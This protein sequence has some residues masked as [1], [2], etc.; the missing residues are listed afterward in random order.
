MVFFRIDLSNEDGLGHYNRVKS[1]IKH[2]DLKKYKIVIDK[3][4]NISFFQNE[5]NNIE[6]LYSD[7]NSF[8]SEKRDAILF[9]KLIGNNYRNP[10]VVKDSYR[11][12]LTWEKHIYKFCNKIITIE[13]FIEKKH[14]VDYYINYSPSFLSKNN[15]SIEMLKKRNKKNCTF[16]LGPEYALF[17]SNLIKTK[18][19]VSDL[20]FYNGGSGDLLIYENIIKKISK[21]K[22]KLFKIILI[23]GPLAKNY[24]IIYQKF[25]KYQNVKVLYQPKNILN[26]LVGTKVFI[27]SAGLSIFESSFLK[28]PTLLFKM[29]SN[30]NLS[31]FDYEKLGHYFSLEKQ[32]LKYSNQIVNLIILMLK[33]RIEI[34]KMMSKSSLNIKKIKKNYQ[35]YFKF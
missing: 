15:K 24:K 23:V 30:Q 3:P 8:K 25:K 9:L 20:V 6:Y 29:N 28:V 1:L 5:I 14:F 13:D 21:I 12:G 35:K 10:V 32:D 17:N 16:L 4:S 31:D 26:T 19:K 27:S 33:N 2:L 18:K 22:K 11:L 34:K 7:D